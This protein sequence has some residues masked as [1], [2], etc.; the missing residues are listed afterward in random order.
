MSGGAL[1]EGN[2]RHTEKRGGRGG[3]GFELGGGAAATALSAE[4]ALN[5]EREGEGR[6]TQLGKGK[7]P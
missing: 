5:G 3:E 2:A 1:F 6:R 7:C 4:V